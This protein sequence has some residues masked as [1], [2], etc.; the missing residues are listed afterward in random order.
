VF[1]PSLGKTLGQLRITQGA[2]QEDCGKKLKTITR[3][4]AGQDVEVEIWEKCVKWK[5]K[6]KEFILKKSDK[7]TGKVSVFTLPASELV[8]VGAEG[9]TPETK[10]GYHVVITAD[11]CKELYF[12]QL[13]RVCFKY[14]LANAEEPAACNGYLAPALG[15]DGQN[16]TVQSPLDKEFWGIDTFSSTTKDSKEQND[17]PPKYPPKLSDKKQTTGMIDWAG[18]GFRKLTEKEAKDLKARKYAADIKIKYEY[19]FCT[20]VYCDGKLLAAVT[21]GFVEE[22]TQSKDD[23]TFSG[24]K[25]TPKAIS[26][27]DADSDAAKACEARYKALKD[28]TETAAK[29]VVTGQ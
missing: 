19:D 26:V 22:V 7:S 15:V 10:G 20:L 25:V 27:V 14:W 28:A 8:D 21:W 2:K 4:F 9:G 17:A 1:I 29:K 5:F 23:G 18:A 24:Y 13:V 16:A 11:D 3:K 12:V 6:K